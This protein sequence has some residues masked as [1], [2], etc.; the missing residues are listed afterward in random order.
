MIKIQR[1]LTKR[2]KSY[3]KDDRKSMFLPTIEKKG[4][5]E[6]RYQKASNK[7]NSSFSVR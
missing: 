2:E 4:V 5:N 7:M 3:K 6:Q 1:E